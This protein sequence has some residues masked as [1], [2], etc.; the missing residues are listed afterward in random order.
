MLRGFGVEYTGGGDDAVLEVLIRLNESVRIRVTKGTP[1]SA[2]EKVS[3]SIQLLAASGNT[4]TTIQKP[5]ITKR[6]VPNSIEKHK[7]R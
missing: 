6:T 5:A 4:Y 7:K 3:P 1:F 2:H